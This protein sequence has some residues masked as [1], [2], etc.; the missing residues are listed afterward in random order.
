MAFLWQLFFLLVHA[1]LLLAQGFPDEPVLYNGTKFSTACRAALETNLTSCHPVLGDFVTPYITPELLPIEGLNALC[2]AACRTQLVSVKSNIASK[3]TASTDLWNFDGVPYPATFRVDLMLNA[4]DISCY[5]EKSTSRFCDLV[6]AE[7]RNGSKPANYCSDC[8]LGPARALLSSPVGYDAEVAADFASATVNCSATGYSY[9]TSTYPVI[10]TSSTTGTASSSALPTSTGCPGSTRAVAAGD[11]CHSVAKAA[12]V[13]TYGLIAANNLDIFCSQL[14]TTACLPPTCKTYLW[15]PY[16]ICEE[17]AAKSNI[18]LAQFLAWNPNFDAACTN[19]QEWR[20]WNVCIGPPGGASPPP[21]IPSAVPVP[22]NAHPRSN[23]SCAA[24]HNV[25]LNENCYT[26]LSTGGSVTFAQ[27]LVLNPDVNVN[28]TNL[29]LY[30]SYCVQPL[31][32]INI[33]AT[34]VFTR[35]P[36]SS[37]THSAYTV[38]Y[39]TIYPKAPNTETNCSEYRNFIPLANDTAGDVLLP[40]IPGANLINSCWYVANKHQIPLAGLLFWNP[41]LNASNCNLQPGRS[42]CVAGGKALPVTVT[43]TISGAPTSSSTKPPTTSSSTKP[44]TTS[45]STK[46]PTTLSSTKPS[47]S[48]KPPSTSSIKPT[49]TTVS[50]TR[51]SSSSTRP[52]TSTSTAKV[53]S[54]DGLCGGN[55]TCQGS[56]FGNCCS[57]WGFCGSTADYCG[58]GCQRALGTCT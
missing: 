25:T 57:Q 28:C 31:T 39:P 40:A 9:S 26:I 2:V 8:I 4:Y 35:P 47:S 29:W 12:G 55:V 44:A 19:A 11:T 58:A 33:P 54:P 32:P 17:V 14:E 18:T 43:G 3:C 13:S 20:G 56:Q 37:S 22:A 23:R 10:R 21:P 24:W 38:V 42:Y 46:P 16:D 6:L 1:H 48:T 51:T 36:I 34:K 15:A 41:S 45:S 27:F 30:T 49:T 7:M 5:K 50:S 52:Q 53:I